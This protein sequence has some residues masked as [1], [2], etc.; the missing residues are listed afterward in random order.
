MHKVSFNQLQVARV[1]GVDLGVIAQ[2]FSETGWSSCS[3]RLLRSF[4]WDAKHRAFE[5]LDTEL[6]QGEPLI[7]V[8]GPYATA[9]AAAFNQDPQ[10][11]VGFP[12]REDYDGVL[13]LVHG[14]PPVAGERY[15]DAAGWIVAAGTGID[16]QDRFVALALE[17][18]NTQLV[19][20]VLENGEL[21]ISL[22]L[23]KQIYP[24]EA[25][26]ELIELPQM[27]ITSG[28]GDLQTAHAKLREILLAAMPARARDYSAPLIVDTW[29]FG[30]NVNQDL[31]SAVAA[32]A[33]ELDLEILTIDKG[34]ERI[35]GEWQPGPHFQDGLAG[36]SEI[37]AKSG[38]RLGLWASL[39]NVDPQASIAKA[40]PDWI[41]T[42]RGKV[43]VV[44]HRTSSFCM[45]HGPVI[46]Y[47]SGELSHLAEN[48]LTWLLHDFETINRCDSDKHDHPQG[49]GEDWAVRGWYRL[50]SQFRENYPDVWIE[51]CWNGGKPLDLQMLAHH[52]T[53]IG[54]DW[55][56]VR[57]NA[58]AK[59]GLGHYL[60]AHWCS[61][62][63][64]DQNSLP[65]KSQLA[66]YAVGGPWILMGDIPNWSTEK[67]TL[68][69]SVMGVYKTWRPLFA[70]GSVGWAAIT[71]WKPDSR[72]RADQEVLA[73]S[74]VHPSGKELMACVITEPLANK[75]LIWHPVHE[76][77]MRIVNEFTGESTDYTASEVRAGIAIPASVADGHLFSAVLV[78]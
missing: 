57:H 37:T 44:S 17:K 40:H 50:I 65:L 39:G 63:M 32:T 1:D 8:C 4:T 41:A 67:L 75:E 14:E 38:T 3:V 6:V 53:T 5:T 77:A 51:N 70:S 29:G 59:V 47:L 71:G 64:S 28:A 30:T 10:Q 61:S 7:A 24:V 58:V 27:Q 33:K 72:W 25:C 48:G 22:V 49:L 78:W 42:W 43:Q 54:D 20:M 16:G 31:V 55:C 21:E 69:K 18:S 56:D 26:H 35:V 66:I 73:I 62:Y 36:L 19:H 15:Q 2:T 9:D 12:E 11:D 46:D 34:W 45:G 13:Y 52:D 23:P 74:F 68:A 76:G 60:P